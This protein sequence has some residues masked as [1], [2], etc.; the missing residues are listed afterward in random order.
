MYRISKPV[1]RPC[2][3]N[4]IRYD[5]FQQK[6]INSQRSFCIL[7]GCGCLPTGEEKMIATEKT[8]CVLKNSYLLIPPVRLWIFGVFKCLWINI[9]KPKLGKF[10]IIMLRTKRICNSRPKAVICLYIH[11]SRKLGKMDT[12]T[13]SGFQS[14]NRISLMLYYRLY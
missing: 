11:I 5:L 9:I 7:F 14:R 12:T 6:K 4:K 8:I 10:V 3:Y 1:L 13:D 2:I